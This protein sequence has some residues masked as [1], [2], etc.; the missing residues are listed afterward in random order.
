MVFG[1]SLKRKLIVAS[2]AKSRVIELVKFTGI[3]DYVCK[4]GPYADDI[5]C[6]IEFDAD[7]K[8]F[9]SLLSTLSRDDEIS[10][11]NVLYVVR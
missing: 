8:A 2:E 9:E 1:G 10:E 3:E 4:K 5:V 6:L 11:N 7:D